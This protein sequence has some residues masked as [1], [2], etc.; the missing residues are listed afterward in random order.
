[1][2]PDAL[3]GLAYGFCGAVLA[4]LALWRYLTRSERRGHRGRRWRDWPK[5]GRHHGDS[6]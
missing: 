6:Q 4:F 5:R 2:S 1:M 3:W